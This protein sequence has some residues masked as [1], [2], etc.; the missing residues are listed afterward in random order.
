[1]SVND[2]QSV[3]GGEAAI[4]SGTLPEVTVTASKDKFY[5]HLT[6]LMLNGDSMEAI[7]LFSGHYSTKA[8]IQ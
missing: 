6:A 7:Y 3:Y 8:N 4:D 2:M 1:M 5:N